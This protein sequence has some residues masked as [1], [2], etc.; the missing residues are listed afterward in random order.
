MPILILLIENSDKN[1]WCF[2]CFRTN[3]Y[4][5]YEGKYGRFQIQ[6]DGYDGYVKFDYKILLNFFLETVINKIVYKEYSNI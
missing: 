1:I 2:R 4:G 3:K 5:K 6:H